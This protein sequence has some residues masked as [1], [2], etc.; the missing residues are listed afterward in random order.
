MSSRVEE[1]YRL[2]KFNRQD[3]SVRRHG[4]KKRRVVY[5]NAI[6]KVL[7]NEGNAWHTS[8]EIADKANEYISAFW[9]QLN[10]F[11][12]AAIL[13]IYEAD[14]IIESKRTALCHPKKYRVIDRV[15]L[16]P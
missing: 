1:E 5:K 15:K 7:L 14:N 12:V 8:T 9:T 10:C 13:R 11:S 3:P 4:P 6:E 2:R 16:I